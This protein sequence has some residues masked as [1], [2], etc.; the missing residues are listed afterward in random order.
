MLKITSLSALFF[1]VCTSL[2]HAEWTEIHADNE[3]LYYY[4]LS[5]RLAGPKPRISALRSFRQPTA[6]GDQSAKLLYEADC[7]NQKIRMMSGVYTKNKTGDGEV[8][9]MINS[10]GWMDPSSRIV[11]EKLFAA[12]C[13]LDSPAR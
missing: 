5:T 7:T 13:E 6:H 12:L 10:N 1:S 4:D 3:M 9:G 8:S 11:L 2:C